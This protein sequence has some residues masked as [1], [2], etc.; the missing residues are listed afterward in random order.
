MKQTKTK[1]IQDE[2]ISLMSN[3]KPVP[4]P[5]AERLV[6]HGRNFIP[7]SEFEDVEKELDCDFAWL[8]LYTRKLLDDITDVNQ[9]EKSLMIMWNEHVGKY[10]GLGKV[11]LGRL[12]LDFVDFHFHIISDLN[13]YCNFVSL[14]TA[15]H[16]DHGGHRHAHAGVDEQQGPDPQ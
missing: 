3:S 4:T 15:L 11:N 14:M 12:L 7:L 10:H 8:S 9:A 1:L 6:F 13:L 2:A 5:L 16:G